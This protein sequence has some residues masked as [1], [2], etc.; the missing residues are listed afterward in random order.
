MAKYDV[1]QIDDGYL[2]D[3][4]ASILSDLNTR[5]MVPLM[6]P[7]KAPKP[8]RRLNPVFAIEKQKLLMITQYIATVPKNNL[9]EPITNLAEHFAEITNAL[10]MLFQGY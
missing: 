1:Y 9:G 6:L 8:A 7:E 2:L 4:Q 3:V 5:V 10:D